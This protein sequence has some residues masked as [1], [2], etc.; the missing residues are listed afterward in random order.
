MATEFVSPL[1]YYLI[2]CASEPRLR[3][4]WFLVLP[5]CHTN[6]LGLLLKIVRPRIPFAY[7]C[8]KRLY[9]DK[10]KTDN[11]DSKPAAGFTTV[12]FGDDNGKGELDRFCS[13]PR[14]S[15]VV[16]LFLL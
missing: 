2:W 14:F 15:W 5:V 16:S 11:T 6:V 3:P 4:L 12:G 7:I 13:I 10:T 9:T 8:R 1:F